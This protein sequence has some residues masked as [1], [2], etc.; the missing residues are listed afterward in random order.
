ME[1]IRNTVE[2]SPSFNI[3]ATLSRTPTLGD[4]GLEIE[5]EG[6]NLPGEVFIYDNSKFWTWHH[7]GSLRGSE[8]AEYVLKSPIKFREVPEALDELWGFF[9]KLK[10]II[11][12]SNRTSV[13]VHLNV[14]KF[15]FN[16]LASFIALYLCVEEIITDWCGEHRVG[17]LFCLR[18]MDAPYI[19]SAIKRFIQRDGRNPIQDALHYGAM[20]AHAI[21]KYGSLEFR[22]LRGTPEISVIQDWVNILQRL[23]EL[24]ADYEDPRDIP[25]Q[26]SADGP[27]MFI[28]TLLGD[29]APGIIASTGKTYDDV[30]DSMFKGIRIAQE[31]CY[32]RD[33]GAFKKAEIQADPFNRSM[34]KIAK[35]LESIPQPPSFT[36]SLA[37]I[38]GQDA[39][40]TE[41]SF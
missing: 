15:H 26:F 31:I 38:Y 34:K 3:G 10:S 40:Q 37:Q 20:N 5:V 23:Y 32:C 7:D 2:E 13:H 8:N 35:K 30:R 6:K 33:W 14:Q 29:L 16:R 19:V 4:I 12:D 36:Q 17:N 27:N 25:A 24:S 22:Q 11:D 28:E 18:A 21:V 9:Y 1:F 41:P 39:N